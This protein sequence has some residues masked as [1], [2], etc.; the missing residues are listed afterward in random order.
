MESYDVQVWT[1]IDHLTKYVSEGNP[2]RNKQAILA[3]SSLGP[4]EQEAVIAAFTVEGA[5]RL[6]PVF[7]RLYEAV[8]Y[9]ELKILR[10]YFLIDQY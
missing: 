5:D 3:R 9:D 7:D 4:A 8:S 6:K 1:I 10:L 2:L